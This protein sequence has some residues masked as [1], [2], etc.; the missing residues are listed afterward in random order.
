MKQKRRIILF[1]HPRSGSSSLYQIL[2]LHPALN[3]LEEPFNENFTRWSDQNPD[4]RSRVHDVPSLDAVLAEVFAAFNGVKVLN[5][6]LAPDLA[7]HLLYHPDCCVIF[8][9]RRNLLQAIVSV[10][11]AH[12]TNLWKKWEMTR[13]LESYYHD[14]QPLDIEDVRER[15]AGM[16]AS[17]D[18]C[19]TMLDAR[20][21]GAVMKL[22][23][24]EL[25]YA[26]SDRRTTTIDALWTWLGL[27]RLDLSVYQRFIRPEDARINSVDTYALLPNAEEINRV[28]GS[29]DTGWLLT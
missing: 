14:L 4:Y 1:A 7:K 27:E 23:Y 5:Y 19:E 17:L 24:E 8:L 18:T 15:V 28:C 2:Q 22:V 10:L 25:Y 21:D 26:P 29:D 6:Q 13:P 9:R 16:K 20:P 11:I 12:Q 3:I